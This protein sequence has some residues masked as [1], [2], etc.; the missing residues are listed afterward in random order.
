MSA[1]T[2]EPLLLFE[3]DDE[4]PLAIR[5]FGGEVRAFSRRCPG[6]A[7]N[8]DAW[9]LVPYGEDGLLV[10]ADGMG[11]QSGARRASRTALETLAARLAQGAGTDEPLRHALFDGI[12]AANRAGGPDNISAVLIRR[13]L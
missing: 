4:E 11:G 10:V 6:K 2:M 5:A 1:T 3:Q 8:E 12:E 13:M 7:A 9:A